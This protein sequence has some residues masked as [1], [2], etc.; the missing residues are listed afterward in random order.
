[1]T[2]RREGGVRT[3]IADYDIIRPL[4]GVDTWLAW[5]PPRLAAGQDAVQVTRVTT[6]PES[7]EDVVGFL[8]HLARAV[9]P[10]LPTLLE[11]GQD[12][13]GGASVADVE[14][15]DVETADVGTADVGTADVGTADVGTADGNRGAAPT[16][17]EGDTGVAVARYWTQHWLG[18][19]TLASPGSS[20]AVP[21]LLAA[22][23]AAARGAHA[24]HQVGLVHGHISAR[25]IHLDGPVP[26]LDLPPWPGDT[27]PGLIMV[28]QDP[29][30]LD[31][32]DPSVLRGGSPS[33]T[34]DIWALGAVA[35]R[36]LS[37]QLLH[38]ALSADPPVTAVQ[39]AAFEPPTLD[40]GLDQALADLLGSCLAP[41]PSRRPRTAAELADRLD[42]LAG[43]P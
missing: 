6:T 27:P 10:H 9:S 18:E 28:L 8:R 38:P 23:A 15:A 33:R 14:T 32:V 26:G 25:A 35:H 29:A 11:Y 4:S 34:T 24:L 36:A 17:P 16:G 31:T 19:N 7:W 13:A 40:P 12:D 37:G 43:R 2:L 39:R 21:G 5:P 30:D 41:D 1:M 22:L 20:R 42:A 3:R